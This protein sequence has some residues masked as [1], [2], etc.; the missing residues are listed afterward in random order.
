MQ[1]HMLIKE[2]PMEQTDVSLHPAISQN[3]FPW[4]CEFANDVFTM[5][6]PQYS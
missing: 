4:G 3:R 2:A 1:L 6:D 5:V